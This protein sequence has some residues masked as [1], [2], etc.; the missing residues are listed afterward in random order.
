MEKVKVPEKPNQIESSNQMDDSE[1]KTIKESDIKDPTLSC[2]TPIQKYPWYKNKLKLGLIIGIGT[3]V[4]VIAIIIAV[5][6][7]NK[8]K[9]INECVG[10]DCDPEEEEIKEEEEEEEVIVD[11]KYKKGEVNV[12]NDF[13]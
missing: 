1:R 13:I 12:Y 5:V 9:K 6:T 4:I 2:E 8:N 10:N 11:I 7:L 3:L